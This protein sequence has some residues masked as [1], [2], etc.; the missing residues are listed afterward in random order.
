LYAQY[1]ENYAQAMETYERAK[2]L[3]DFASFLEVP[4]RMYD[5]T[6]LTSYAEG[7]EGEGG[8]KA[9]QSTKELFELSL[10]AYSAD[11]CI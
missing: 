6:T 3:K 2:R 1:S 9:C 8:R 4:A 5:V 10:S 11:D 7:A